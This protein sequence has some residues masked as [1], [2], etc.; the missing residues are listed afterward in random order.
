MGRLIV[1][2]LL[3]IVAVWLIR[4]A[5]RASAARDA[6]KGAPA[7]ELVRCAHCGV[8]LP[9]AEARSSGD[10]LYCSDEHARLGPRQG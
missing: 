4:R 2:V 9:R 3:L 7:G 8:H 1:L 6:T 5:L 10:A